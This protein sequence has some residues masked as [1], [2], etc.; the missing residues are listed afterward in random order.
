MTP[1][2]R[3]AREDDLPAITRIYG[4]HVRTGTASFET[5]PPD[6]AE[7]LARYRAIREKGLPYLVAESDGRVAGYAYA[8]LY[9][10]RFAY[11]FTLE[12]SIYVDPAAARAGIGRALL[13]RLVAACEA[14][15]A[16]QLVAVIG[17]SGN[18]A[19][20]RLH[21]ALGFQPAGVLRHVGWKHGRWL[22]SVLM[23]RELGAGA[24]A[25]P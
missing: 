23:Q 21:A 19:S 8:S 6:E 15:G 3:D 14:A 24:G 18:E 25:P 10:T 20:I 2:L 7:M 4:H 11:R 17:D 22:D 9:R 5:E 12:D 16:R 1:V 13:A